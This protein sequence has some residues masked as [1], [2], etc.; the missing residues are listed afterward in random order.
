MGGGHSVHLANKRR[1]LIGSDRPVTGGGV[2]LDR[3]AFTTVT[4]DRTID[5]ETLGNAST[6][7]GLSPTP[8]IETLGNLFDE[9]NDAVVET[10]LEDG[11]TNTSANPTGV[12]PNPQTAFR[13]LVATTDNGIQD[14]SGLT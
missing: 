7:L 4:T 3:G 10:M 12:D 14:G 11:Q 2:L 1:V 6:F 8:R 13:N 5:L 9:Q